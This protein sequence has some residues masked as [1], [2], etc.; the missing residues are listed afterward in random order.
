[1]RQVARVLANLTDRPRSKTHKRTGP[2]DHGIR[3]LAWVVSPT[4]PAWNTRFP[5][6]SPLNDRLALPPV[7]DRLRFLPA[8]LCLFL[9]TAVASARAGHAAPEVLQSCSVTGVERSARCGVIEVLENPDRPGSRKLAVHFVVIPAANGHPRPD[10]L[11]LSVYTSKG[12]I[13]IGRY[14]TE[15][16]SEH[17]RTKMHVS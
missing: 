11:R 2:F 9:L 1:M 13:T 4:R 15:C 10:P 6:S 7:V 16:H 8:M 3:V 14:K 5:S 12:A 17:F